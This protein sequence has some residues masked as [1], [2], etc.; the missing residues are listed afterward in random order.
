MNSQFPATRVQAVGA[1]AA[2]AF[3]LS[4]VPS[5]QAQELTATVSPACEGQVV[6]QPFTPWVDPAGYVLVP[7][8]TLET[9]TSWD[10]HGGAAR[11]SGNENF[12]VHDDGDAR[13]LALPSGSSATTAPMC[14]GLD[15]PTLRLFAR[16]GGSP[17]SS[18]L[19]EALFAD[20][21]G[22]MRAVP[23]GA[24]LATSRWQPTIPLAILA[25]LTALPTGDHVDVAFRF[26]PRGAGDWS[27]DDVYVDPFRHG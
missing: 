8:G 16:N 27:I 23:I 11:E 7:N 1:L 14:V 4:L 22:K 10:L 24:F 17:F 26:T 9:G 6:E 3:A 18:L 25:N 2:T 20:A 12:Y 15:Y 13:S 21:S 19:V 5:A